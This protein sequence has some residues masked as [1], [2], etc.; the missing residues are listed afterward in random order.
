MSEFYTPKDLGLASF[1]PIGTR[2]PMDDYIV[3]EPYYFTP[4]YDQYNTKQTVVVNGK[5]VYFPREADVAQKMVNPSFAM[6]RYFGVAF[7]SFLFDGP[8]NQVYT[9]GKG[10]LMKLFSFRPLTQ[11]FSFDTTSGYVQDKTGSAT[12]VATFKNRVT[13]G[14]LDSVQVVQPGRGYATSAADTNAAFVHPTTLDDES[15]P[16]SYYDTRTGTFASTPLYLLEEATNEF[17]QQASLSVLSTPTAARVD[18][19]MQD[20]T[21]VTTLQAQYRA[22]KKASLRRSAEFH[23][24]VENMT[25]RREQQQQRPFSTIV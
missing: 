25:S 1:I 23:F 9:R 13:R 24:H 15:K 11:L 5:S 10:N 4:A 3:K 6:G 22:S 7:G 14:V 18:V 17:V 16:E 19:A 12:S 8:E 2:L 20:D 21:S